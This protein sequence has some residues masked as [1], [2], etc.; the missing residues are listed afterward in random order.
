V[1]GKDT[2]SRLVKG[3][4]TFSMGEAEPRSL[5]HDSHPY[6]STKKHKKKYK[7]RRGRPS[8]EAKERK[9]RRW[10]AR[11]KAKEMMERQSQ[12]P[13]EDS[14]SEQDMMDVV[15]LLANVEEQQVV[16]AEVRGVSSAT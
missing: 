2:K 3:G 4:L 13:G 15:D 8:A 6:D 11:I 5:P 1:T 10:I 14:E 16:V 12:C 7:T 9:T